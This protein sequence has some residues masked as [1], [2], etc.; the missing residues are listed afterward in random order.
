[1]MDIANWVMICCISCCIDEY[2]VKKKYLGTNP[3]NE[4]ASSCGWSK[5]NM[6]CPSQ[7]HLPLVVRRHMVV[8]YRPSSLMAFFDPHF[9]PSKVFMMAFWWHFREEKPLKRHLVPPKKRRI[10]FFLSITLSEGFSACNSWTPTTGMEVE[11]VAR[12]WRL[13]TSQKSLCHQ[14]NYLEK[15]HPKARKG[16]F[17]KLKKTKHW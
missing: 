10:I 2:I 5:L 8:P 14:Q 4:N 7:K 15:T 11:N 3:P 9:L 17:C 12:K 6:S 13:N 1:M 16:I